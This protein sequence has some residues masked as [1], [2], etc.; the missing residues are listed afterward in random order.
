MSIDVSPSTNTTYYAD[1]F[2]GF[3]TVST[4][5]EIVLLPTT[6]ITLQP[7]DLILLEGNTAEFTISANFANSYQWQV[8]E[9]G[10][11]TWIDLTNENEYSGID[12]SS[13]LIDP[14]NTNMHGNLYRCIVLGRCNDLPSGEATLNVYYFP[15]FESNLDQ[16]KVC[17]ND[18]FSVACD[19]YNFNQIIDFNFSIEFDTSLLIYKSIT[20]IQPEITN[21]IQDLSSGKNITVSW[22]SSQEVTLPD[23]L[24]FNFTFIAKS[25]GTPEIIWDNQFC[26]VTN[27][28]GFHPNM[29]LTD[30]DIE[31]LPLPESPV[32]AFSDKDTIN[33]ID[34]I[35]ITLTAIGGLGDELIWSSGS[36]YGDTIG[37]GTPMEIPRPENTS[38]YYAYWQNQCGVSNCVDVLIVINS[39]FNINIPNA[40]T[41]NGDGLNDEFGIVSN[42]IFEEFNMQIYN[43][44]GQLIYETTDQT[45]GWDGTYK[46]NKV[47]KGAYIWKIAYNL[48][49]TGPFNKKEIETGTLILVN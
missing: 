11:S 23:G 37:Y 6:S 7:L 3:T 39:D 25:E 33:I 28:P 12:S 43:R 26:E 16:D 15:D 2:D 19:V 30:G 21:N 48:K 14:V 27:E 31:I 5:I 9:D 41:P 38:I 10:G 32:S 24:L 13:L 18:T 49:S 34:V 20:N 1:V 4:S 40:F 29:I 46:G 45:L 8:S 17:A 35:D 36:C 42:T 44:W 22:N 47:K